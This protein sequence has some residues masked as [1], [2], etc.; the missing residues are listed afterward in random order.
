MEAVALREVGKMKILNL[1]R[2]D[3]VNKENVYDLAKRIAKPYFDKQQLSMTGATIVDGYLYV[4]GEDR[5]FPHRS[6]VIKIDLSKEKI[7]ESYGARGC[8]VTIYIGQY[9]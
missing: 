9:E 4:E 5:G 6:D 2:K 3:K 1:F 8:P 7:I